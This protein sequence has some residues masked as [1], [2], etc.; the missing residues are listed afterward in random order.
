M[1]QKQY[2]VATRSYEALPRS[3]RLRARGRSS[4]SNHRNAGGS[5]VVMGGG[6]GH[7]HA[8]K[9]VLDS[10]SMDV[11]GY[12]YLKRKP[13]DEADSTTE[14]VKAG[15]AD[16][17][18]HAEKADDSTQW[19][20]NQFTDYLNQPLRKEDSVNF[21]KV[22]AQMFSTPDYKKGDMNGG[23]GAAVYKEGDSTVME[24]DKLIVRKEAS[25]SEVVINQTTFQ[26]GE[27][28]FSRGGCSLI[29]VETFDD[30][31]RCYYDNKAGKRYSGFAEG[32]LARCQRFDESYGGIIKYYWRKVVAL[33]NEAG[34]VD[35]S[36]VSGE[37]DG[38]GE[39]AAGDDIVHFGNVEEPSRQS[40]LVISPLNGG[41]LTVLSAINSFSLTGTDYVGMGVR[42]DATYKA[43]RAYIYGYGDVYFGDRAK[44]QF[45][46]YVNGVMNINANITIG[47]ES[48]YGDTTL[49]EAFSAIETVANSKNKVFTGESLPENYNI[50][51]IWIVGEDYSYNGYN[52]YKGQIY[53]ATKAST[54]FSPSHWTLSDSSIYDANNT[55]VGAKNATQQLN[56]DLYL[57]PLEKS[58]LR[59]IMTEL[60]DSEGVAEPYWAE[61]THTSNLGQEWYLV[62][63]GDKSNGVSQSKWID[64]W[65][66]AIAGQNSG[67]T[68]SVLSI[69]T[70]SESKRELSIRYASDGETTWD[71][72]TIRDQNNTVLVSTSG[73]QDNINL[74]YQV[75]AN[76]TY[77]VTYRKDSSDNYGTDAG[78]YKVEGTGVHYFTVA[79]NDELGKQVVTQRVCYKGSYP[80]LY[81]DLY[82]AG[83]VDA[84]NTLHEKFDS[85]VVLLQEAKVYEDAPTTTYLPSLPLSNWRGVLQTALNDYANYVAMCQ[86]SDVDYLKNVFP[87]AVLDSNGAVLSKLVAVKGG[88]GTDAN[89]VAGLY[90]GGSDELNEGTGLYDDAHGALM[91]FAGAESLDNVSESK[92]RIY[93]D[94]H[95]VFNDVE[96][97]G[98]FKSS[99]GGKR[100]EVISTKDG[101]DAGM[102]V[103]ADNEVAALSEND[104]PEVLVTSFTSERKSI[105]DLYTAASVTV[106]MTNITLSYHQSA[107]QVSASQEANILSSQV[108]VTT[109]GGVLK[110]PTISGVLKIDNEG[111]INPNA[112]AYVNVYVNGQLIHTEG[113]YNK[114]GTTATKSFTIAARQMP[115]PTGEIVIKAVFMY[116]VADQ[117]LGLGHDFS[118]E[119]RPQANGLVDYSQYVA[120]YFANGLALGSSSSNL[121]TAINE[122]G[123]MIVRAIADQYG[124]NITK[125]GLQL[126]IGSNWYDA[127]Y[128]SSNNSLQLM[129][130]QNIKK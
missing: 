91:M 113:I 68:T 24:I 8:N 129:P 87:N 111:G 15:W 112:N 59:Q 114:S 88:T 76:G 12:L 48:K 7:T 32:D 17:S 25:F 123:N 105:D 40:A 80:A 62:K 55:A 41:S 27:T 14:K 119:L 1:A 3:K 94:G 58:N 126:R 115:S 34:Y 44:S 30:Y 13:A 65:S 116:A 89:I 75:T 109:P 120:S 53:K 84:A 60:S 118:V 104:S 86:L 45:I 108:Q 28:V 103:F 9:S 42:Y 43:Y 52:F 61:I 16:K 107:S 49:G 82:N 66:S 11:E 18:G 23:A 57:T 19:N 124:I 70:N 51:D 128:N 102:Y 121:F 4:E 64:W 98:G 97:T 47:A 29:H 2:N 101:R 99:S 96:T 37:Y 35:L 100:I 67:S 20:G 125:N 31:Y 33:D 130:A 117:Q 10:Q 92:T 71:Y 46:E 54:L 21:L 5:V 110:L 6:D 95:A 73:N 106:P 122:G 79:V 72:L 93:E 81:M 36:R 63:S 26:L 77:R 74:A 56:D 38:M 69:S 39:P 50:G 85:I 22:I 78:Y 127:S 90:G 83:K